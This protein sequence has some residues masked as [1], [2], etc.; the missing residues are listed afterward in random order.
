[1]HINDFW[2]LCIMKFYFGLSNQLKYLVGQLDSEEERLRCW[3]DISTFLILYKYNIVLIFFWYVFSLFSFNIK[4]NEKGNMNI[5][6]CCSFFNFSCKKL[7]Q[8]YWFF[9]HLPLSPEFLAYV[10][11]KGKS[12]FHCSLNNNSFI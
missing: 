2:M 12:N 7:T 1:M 3:C 4:L 6:Y 10:S 8:H 11:W 5:V 9:S